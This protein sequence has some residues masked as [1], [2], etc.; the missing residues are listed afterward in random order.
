M[1]RKLKTLL[2]RKRFHFFFMLFKK[3]LKITNIWDSSFASEKPNVKSLH[4]C[5]QKL[6]SSGQFVRCLLPWVKS[7]EVLYIN[8]LF[9]FNRLHTTAKAVSEAEYS[10]YGAA[11]PG[12]QV[13]QVHC[14][15]II[16]IIIMMMMMM[17][18]MI[19]LCY[20]EYSSGRTVDNNMELH[21]S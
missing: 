19:R 12:P 1:S 9:H 3:R 21:I 20:L 13:S 15:I 5:A 8:T 11:K 6:S 7:N 4:L 10:A 16:I 18:M 17:M 2:N 14:I